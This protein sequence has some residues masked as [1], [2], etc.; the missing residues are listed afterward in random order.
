MH[1]TSLLNDSNEEDDD[2]DIDDDDDTELSTTSLTLL[3]FAIGYYYTSIIPTI[4]VHRKKVLAKHRKP[5]I[6]RGPSSFLQRLEWEHFTSVHAYRKDFQRH[7]R[8]PYDSFK[9]LVSVLKDDLMVDSVQAGF[10]GGAIIPEVCLYVCLRY[11]A[12]GSYTDIQILTGIS[13][14]SFYRILWK[15]INAINNSKSTLLTIKF[16]STNKES[17]D[18]ALGF[19]SISQQ[20]CIWNCVGV[21][22]GYHLQIDTPSKTEAKNVKSFFSGHYQTFGVNVQATCDHNCRFTFIGVAGPGVMGDRDAIGQVSLKSLVEA[23]PGLYCIIGDCAYTPTEHLVPIFRG[24]QALSPKNDNF[25]FYASQLR[26]RT[27]VV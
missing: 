1:N 12:G 11:L 6:P 15:T 10:R 2:D 26:I 14:S 24:D 19:Q 13:V 22:D 4:Y 7:I 25:N 9:K 16:P 5:S 18:A 21:V 3:Y 23:L 17:D 20:G 27:F 8:M